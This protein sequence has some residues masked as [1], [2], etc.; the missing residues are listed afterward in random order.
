V[1]GSG[2]FRVL[3]DANGRAVAVETLRSTGNSSLDEAAVSALHEWRS[4][5][6]REWSLVV[7][8]TFKQ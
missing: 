6:G 7:P 2:S 8:I 1:Q 5:P 4:E 3:F